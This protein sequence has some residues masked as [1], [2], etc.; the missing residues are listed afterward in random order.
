[1]LA[2]TADD[3]WQPGIGDPTVI[4]WLTVVAYFIATVFCWKATLAAKKQK[5]DKEALFWLL[6]TSFLLCLGINKQ[7]DLQ[8]WFTL[9]GKHLA[10]QEGWYGERRIFQAVFI[11]MVT[12]V[13]VAGWIICW[14]LA[15]KTV[16]HYGLALTGGMFLA[17]F[18]LIRAASFHYV[19]QMLGLKLHYFTLNSF[20]E[21][22]GILCVAMAAW[23]SY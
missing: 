5:R 10:E 14:R 2:F 3:H 11:A 19:D 23:K 21:L 12:L 6:F 20:L 8:T 9:F 16:R 13:A 7:L 22:G 18:I 1:M 4:G 17:C 15:R